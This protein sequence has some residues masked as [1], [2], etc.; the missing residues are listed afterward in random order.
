LPLKK[1]YSKEAF[2]RNVKTEIRAGRPTKQAVA[3]AY[4]VAREARK[5]RREAK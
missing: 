3:I 5:K 1:G 2:A 4:S